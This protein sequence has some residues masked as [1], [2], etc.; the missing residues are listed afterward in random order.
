MN[1]FTK[2]LTT[3]II[4]FILDALLTFPEMLL[5][6]WLMPLIFGITKLTFWQMF[7]FNVFVSLLFSK[8]KTESK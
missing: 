5:W 2:F 4:M 1:D 3:L 7:G 6:N 8:I